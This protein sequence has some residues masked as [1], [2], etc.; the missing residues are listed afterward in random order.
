MNKGIHICTNEYIL[1]LNSGD[2]FYDSS[3]F[4]QLSNYI[5]DEDLIYGDILDCGQ[6]PSKVVSYPD[7]LSFDYMICGGLPHQATA[8]KKSLFDKVG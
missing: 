3:S 4:S 2:S 5:G 8:I 7:F 1:F 6:T